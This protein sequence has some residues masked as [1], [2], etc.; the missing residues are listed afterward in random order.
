MKKFIA[1]ATTAIM[2]LSLAACAKEAPTADADATTGVAGTTT[3]QSADQSEAQAQPV[4]LKVFTNLPDRAAGQ[5]L[6]EQTIFDAYMDENPNVVIEVEALNDEAYKTKFKAYAAG[7][8][9]PD[10][11]SVWGQ[12][13]FIDEVIAADLLAELNPEDYADYGFVSG[14]LDGFSADGKLYGLARNTDVMGFYYNAA[15]FEANGWEVPTTYTD[16]LA[17]ADKANAI[18]IS[19]VA[20]D[21]SDKW[22]L[23]IYITDLMQQIDGSGVMAKT[24]DAIANADFS[25]PTFLQAADI[26]RQSVEAGLFQQGF[27]TSDYGTAKNLFANGQ[28]AMFYMGSWEMSMA[29]SEDIPAEVRDNIRAFKMPVVEGGKGSETT[30]AAWNGGGYSVTANSAQKEEAIKLLNY[31]FKPENWTRIAWENGVCMS[32]QNFS[33]YV[34]GNETALQQQF[35]DMV[36]SS[37]N[38]SGTPIGD[39]GTAL[40]KTTCQDVTQE[41]SIG[42]KSSQ[43]YLDALAAGTK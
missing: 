31:M 30:I 36:S 38:F 43:E 42:T 6:V 18:G 26:L 14:S 40:F 19:P 37:T 1:L 27:E 32:A 16:L 29:S 7:S 10:L 21:G 13:G 24:H 23:Y 20:M 11:V 28:A 41:L 35:I 3:A 12:P 8:Q 22:P 39:M 2:M 34:T 9:M 5:G 4:T 33:D 15:I 17:L 25:D